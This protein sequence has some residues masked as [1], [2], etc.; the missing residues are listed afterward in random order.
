VELARV[1]AD[2]DVKIST[3]RRLSAPTGEGLTVSVTAGSA[4]GGPP[5][6]AIQRVS[7]ST[8]PDLVPN[9][10]SQGDGHRPAHLGVHF[11]PAGLRKVK[12]LEPRERTH[13]GGAI[14]EPNDR[15][16]LQDA[17][18]PWSTVGLMETENG[19]GSGTMIGRRLVLTASHVVVWKTDSAGWMKFT[20]AAFVGMAPFGHGWAERVI[21]WKR[22]GHRM[23]DDETAFDYAVVVLDQGLGDP[24]GYAGFRTFDKA[25]LNGNYWQNLGYP[26]DIGGGSKPSFSGSGA[27][28][29]A[30]DFTSQ[31]QTAY[32]LATL[33]T[34]N[35]TS[36][37]VPTGAGGRGSL[38][39]SHWH[40]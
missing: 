22:N 18:F 5:D 23:N 19:W 17:A 37:A 4:I 29:S 27:I 8:L 13:R 34:T 33:L 40:R 6:I 24:S 14:C 28:S 10:M 7:R 31:Q 3:S 9:M 21:C 12:S 35:R 11:K 30:G 26:G 38:A 1:W 25:W 16:I 39:A 32:L 15:Y 2:S 20:P 36:P